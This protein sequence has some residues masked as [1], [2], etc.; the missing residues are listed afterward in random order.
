MHYTCH[1]SSKP[2]QLS[3]ERDTLHLEKGKWRKFSTSP[4]TT[5]L[6]L[7]QCQ[8]SLHGLSFLTGSQGSRLM[9]HSSIRM[10]SIDTG[11]MVAPEDPVSGHLGIRLA[12][13]NLGSSLTPVPDWILRPRLLACPSSSLAP[14]APTCSPV[15]KYQG[16][17]PAPVQGWTLL[18][19]NA[20]KHPH[21]NPMDPESMS[22]TYSDPRPATEI[23]HQICTV[24]PRIRSTL[25]IQAL[26]LLTCWSS[27]KTQ[28]FQQ[29]THLRSVSDGSP[30]ISE[31]ADWWR[32]FP[33]KDSL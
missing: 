20:R 32:A 24:D 9:I 31:W 14:R 22:Y 4:W 23:E 8:A 5:A 16:S 21:T 10:N 19:P 6:G 1:P 3:V 27:H 25:W 13:I 18:T 29:Q 11:Y 17:W 30:R 28:R 2:R 7:H 26:V 33:T 15:P 12:P